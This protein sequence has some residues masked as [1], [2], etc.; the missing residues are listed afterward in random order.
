M[1]HTFS[2][3]LRRAR[4]LPLLLLLLVAASVTG[5]QQSPYYLSLKRDLLYGGAAAGSVVIGTALLSRTPDI[6]L[7]DLRLGEIPDFDLVATRNSSESA[8][9]ASDNAVHAST[10]LPLLL[11][12]GR[13]SRRDAGKLALLFAETMALNQGLTNIVKS[14][15]KRPRPY[16]FD[17]DLD[18]TTIIR[19]ND[20][21]SF[22]S[23]HTSTSAAS[24][25]FFARAFADYYPN[26][27]LKPYAWALGAGL[28]VFTGYLRIR[29]GQHYPS[30]IV[31]GYA[32]GAAVG[33]LVPVLHR[34]PIGPKGMTLS[35]TGNGLYLS[36][37]F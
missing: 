4:L 14:T 24:G 8:R 27:K 12:A 20:R 1:L 34:R 7:S 33:Y 23:G 11:M 9:R 26:S 10:A 19:S 17:E 29:A 15:A 25:F 30:D 36:C 3:S 18:P 5:Q 37:R 28:P 35:P 13:K 22:L 32:L 2:P 21:A 6:V 16:V 31:A